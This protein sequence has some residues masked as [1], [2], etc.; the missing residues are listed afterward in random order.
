MSTM[1]LAYVVMACA[2]FGAFAVVL[3]VTWLT[4]SALPSHKPSDKPAAPAE[5]PRARDAA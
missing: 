4:T 2:A 1:Q 3:F 5:P